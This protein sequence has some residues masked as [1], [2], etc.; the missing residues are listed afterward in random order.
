M[1]K[2]PPPT[3]IKLTK[4]GKY[5][6]TGK[7]SPTS[8]WVTVN[9]RIPYSYDYCCLNFLDHLSCGGFTRWVNKKAPIAD[10]PFGWTNSCERFNQELE[11]QNELLGKSEKT[12][13]TT[14]NGASIDDNSIL[15]ETVELEL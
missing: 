2:K 9:E 5:K 13:Q 12:T 7:K 8:D 15:E 1:F 14:I 11:F 6:L 10:P 4:D 3:D